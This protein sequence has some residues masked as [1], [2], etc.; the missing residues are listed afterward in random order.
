MAE[1]NNDSMGGIHIG[2]VK[3]FINKIESGAIVTNNFNEGNGGAARDL[4]DADIAKAVRDVFNTRTDDGQLLVTDQQQWF[5]IFKV[6]AYYLNYPTKITDFCT[7]MKTSGIL[8]ALGD[9]V[10]SCKAD[11]IRKV[12]SELPQLANSKPASWGLYASINKSYE[13]QW[14]VAKELMEKLGLIG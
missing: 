1:N 10:P 4:K 13:K 9:S 11:S 7:K 12:N 14:N 2:S 8:D 6:A 5:A 3:Q